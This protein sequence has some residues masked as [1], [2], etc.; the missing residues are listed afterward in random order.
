MQIQDG[1]DLVMVVLLEGSCETIDNTTKLTTIEILLSSALRILAEFLETRFHRMMLSNVG[2]HQ[3]W[4]TYGLLNIGEVDTLLSEL[5]M[6]NEVVGN[7]AVVEKISCLLGTR[8]NMRCLLVY[9]IQG[10]GKCVVSHGHDLGVF[11]TVMIV[12]DL[13]HSRGASIRDQAEGGLGPRKSSKLTKLL[14]HRIIPLTMVDIRHQHERVHGSP[15]EDTT[16]L[17]P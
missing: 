4:D 12:R 15:A 6:V 13:V 10:T 17:S 8:N 3:T 16:Q 7:R 9:G 11:D 14:T 2:V 5:M 1:Q